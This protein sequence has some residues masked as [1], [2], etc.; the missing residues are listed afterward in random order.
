MKSSIRLLTILALTIA[1]AGC[2]EAAGSI[3]DAP[4]AALPATPSPSADTS[5]PPPTASP[6]SSPAPSPTAAPTTSPTQPAMDPATLFAADGIGPYVVGADTSELQ[7]RGLI[8]NVAASFH[9]DDSWQHAEATDR[10]AGAVTITFHDGRVTDVSTDSTDFLT[11]SG[12]RV[13]MPLT[14]LE[15]IY[16]NRGVVI[17]GTMGN[18]AFAVH[19]PNTPLGIVFF[20]DETNTT[21]RAMSAGEVERLEEFVVI[22]E[23]C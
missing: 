6:S 22:G 11:P 18:K 15:S 8:S 14:E 12:A 20:L 5:A 10:F 3:G 4:T 1:I 13:G 16:G 9:C 2:S 19:V 21:V 7:S 17:N 23:G